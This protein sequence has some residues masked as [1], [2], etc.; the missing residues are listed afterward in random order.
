MALRYASSMLRHPIVSLRAVASVLRGNS[1]T[2]LRVE[3]RAFPPQLERAFSDTAPIARI[4]VDRS[5]T[6]S[7]PTDD[8]RSGNSQAHPRGT[9]SLP[10][11]HRSRQP[12]ASHAP[13][14]RLRSAHKRSLPG[15]IRDGSRSVHT[16]VTLM[17]RRL[18][19]PLVFLTRGGRGAAPKGARRQSR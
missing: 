2:P 14:A 9:H 8:F 5:P 15:K 16:P 4:L 3:G 18:T 6:L 13:A 7:G 19:S 10:R 11:Y 12:V 1:Q 17:R